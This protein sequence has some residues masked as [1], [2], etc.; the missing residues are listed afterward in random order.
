[1]NL[2]FLIS[3]FRLFCLCGVIISLFL[4]IKPGRAINIQIKF[5]EKINWRMQPVSMPKEIRNTKIMGLC[6]ITV[7]LIAI[8]YMAALWM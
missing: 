7:T 5:Y 8:V 2:I 3:A 1:M 6:L 4:L